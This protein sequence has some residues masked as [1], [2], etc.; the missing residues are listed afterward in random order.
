MNKVLFK[1]TGTVLLII[2]IN[3]MYQ[4]RYTK[5]A[6]TYIK[7]QLGILVSA[8]IGCIIILY[9][10]YTIE[11][12]THIDEKYLNGICLSVF[13]GAGGILINKLYNYYFESKLSRYKPNDEEYLFI[14]TVSFIGIMIR[15]LFDGMA[16]FPVLISLLLGRYMWLDTRD[17]SSIIKSIKINHNR[18]KETAVL[19]LIGVFWISFIEFLLKNYFIVNL[20][21][22]FVY[23]LILYFPYNFIMSKTN[24][25]S[26]K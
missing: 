24:K 17:I 16:G 8:S 26:M 7:N 19:F 21:F 6:C 25:K 2:F 3:I 20:C 23:G 5:L 15:I 1:I 9:S 22:P 4:K 10:Y 18:I 11:N 13:M 14:I 12:L